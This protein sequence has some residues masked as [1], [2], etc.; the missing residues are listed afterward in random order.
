MARSRILF[1]YPLRY[2]IPSILAGGSVNVGINFRPN[3]LSRR[4]WL[5]V[6][7]PFEMHLNILVIPSFLLASLWEFFQR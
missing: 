2:R 6:E 5:D 3:P 7:K 4:K 1:D